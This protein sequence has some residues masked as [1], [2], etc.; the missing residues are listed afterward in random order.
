MG[1]ESHRIE[2]GGWHRARGTS[3]VWKEPGV[4]ATSVFSKRG[5]WSSMFS[6]GSQVPSLPVRTD[7]QEALL[8]REE[9]EPWQVGKG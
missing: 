5:L 6:A 1:A 3:M 9:R 8:T 7:M 4:W 2:N